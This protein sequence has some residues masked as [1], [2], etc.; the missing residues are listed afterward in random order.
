[1]FAEDFFCGVVEATLSVDGSGDA[2]IDGLAFG[3]GNF[4]AAVSHGGDGDVEGKG[5]GKLFF[6]CPLMG[7][8]L[9]GET[10]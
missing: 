6:A 7:A 1:L 3:G 5:D 10:L 9:F 2:V 4:D 8:G